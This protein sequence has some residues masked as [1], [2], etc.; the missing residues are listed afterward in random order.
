MSKLTTEQL[1]AMRARLVMLDAMCTEF[2][3]L[4]D[5]TSGEENSIL[6]SND[7]SARALLEHIDAQE[8]RI[9]RMRKALDDAHE[10]LKAR[11]EVIEDLQR[12]G[13]W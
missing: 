1:D 5:R 6:L 9:E 2:P 11:R 8:R 7:I 13:Q 10:E 4:R 12:R 3:V